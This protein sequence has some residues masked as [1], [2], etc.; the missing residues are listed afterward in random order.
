MAGAKGATAKHGRE[1]SAVITFVCFK[2]R[3]KDPNREFK[4]PYVNTLYRMLAANYDKPFRFVCMTDDSV[5]LIDEVEAMPLPDMVD[6]PAPNGDLYPSCYRRLWLFSAEAAEVFPGQVVCIDVDTLILENVTEFF[7]R[8]EDC[9]MWAD[10]D[11][12]GLKYAGGLWMLRTGTRTHVWD[13]FDP[14]ESPKIT[15]A[16]GLV[17]SD[18]AWM[19]YCLDGEAVWTRADGIYKTRVLTPESK[20][21]ILQTPSNKHK[22][23]MEAFRLMYKQYAQVW[24]SYAS[25]VEPPKEVPTTVTRFKLLK[26]STRGR[27]GEVVEIPP[28]HVE[29]LRKNGIIDE[30]YREPEVRKVVEPQVLKVIQPTVTK[31]KKRARKSAE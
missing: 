1:V 29:G 18:Q 8:D 27:K 10:A 14:V 31:R 20:P 7:D 6:I 5:G 16:A 4:S 28:N 21:L 3:G 9:V 13:D 26:T 19:S 24:Q 22:P 12:R 2:W 11:L 23:W 17:G 30:P 25:E 15:K